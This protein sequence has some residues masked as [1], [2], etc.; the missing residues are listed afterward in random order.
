ML[1]VVIFSEVELNMFSLLWMQALSRLT[2][3]LFV[4]GRGEGGLPSLTGISIFPSFL[5]D[6]LQ[7]MDRGVVINMVRI[8]SV[9]A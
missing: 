1:F 7:I 5:R 2:S 9:A 3:M 8:H 6:M 4:E